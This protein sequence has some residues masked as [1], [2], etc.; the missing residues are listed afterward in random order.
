MEI[1]TTLVL[2][3]LESMV[4]G[5]FQALPN[6]VVGL[7]VFVL[8]YY[9]AK[10]AQSLTRRLSDAYHRPQNL[11]LVLGRL[12]RW[13]LLSLGALVALLIIFPDFSIGQFLQLLG[14]GGL[15]AGIIFRSTL[16][17]FFAGILLLLDEP[18]RIDDQIVVG[19]FEGTIEEIEARSTTIQTYDGRRVILPN[20][21]LLTQAVIVNTAYPQRRVEFDFGIGY[22]DNIEEA[23][24]VILGTLDGSEGVLQDPAPEVLVAGLADSSVTLRARWWIKPPRRRNAMDTRDRI[25]A[26]VKDRLTEHG[27]DLPFPTQQ[28]LFHDQTEET[29][30]DRRRQ[31]EGWPAGRGS[32]PEPHRIADMVRR[33]LGVVNDNEQ[34]PL[35]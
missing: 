14:L 30:G 29:D 5:F 33:T 12:A 22:G 9:G 34:H 4:N 10:G 6:L 27:I 2:D 24:E 1:D 23:R 18:F 26:A 3:Q 32:I 28:I 20:A 13:V 35:R 16:D 17:D 7:I 25:V 31:R 8:F 19:A 21:D 11:G 15:A